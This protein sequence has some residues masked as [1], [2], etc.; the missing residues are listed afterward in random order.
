MVGEGRGLLP[1]LGLPELLLVVLVLMETL[2]KDR[3]YIFKVLTAIG[4]KFLGG[5]LALVGV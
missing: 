3:G 1:L 5:S 2:L 4:A